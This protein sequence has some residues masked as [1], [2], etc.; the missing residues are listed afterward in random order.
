MFQ[1]GIQKWLSKSKDKVTNMK[2]FAVVLI[3]EKNDFDFQQQWLNVV[4]SGIHL[5]VEPNGI[6]WKIRCGLWKS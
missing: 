5:E 4:K 2:V 3:R 1:T 6:Y